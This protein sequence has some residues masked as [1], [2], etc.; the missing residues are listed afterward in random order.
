MALSR[1]SARARHLI[2]K[3][4]IENFFS[5]S[6]FST[7]ERLTSLR[8]KEGTKKRKSFI[9]EIVLEG[10]SERE[11]NLRQ[12]LQVTVPSLDRRHHVTWII[13]GK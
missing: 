4:S 6:F 2:G 7:T 12:L 9:F 1:G 8:E 3:L 5:K 13:S 10:N 11:K